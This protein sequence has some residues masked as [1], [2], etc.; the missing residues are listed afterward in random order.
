MKPLLW[1]ALIGLAAATQA[2]L[3]GMRW[4]GGLRL[5][6]LPALVACGALSGWRPTW[7]ILTAV[8][9]GLAHDA[10]SAGPFGLT[11]V[12]YTAPAVL[13]V[14]LQRSLDRDLPWVQAGAGAVV[15]GFAA[16]L[17]SL[18]AGFTGAALVKI[19]LLAMLGAVLTPLATLVREGLGLRAETTT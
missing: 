10:L 17:G 7:T 5:E 4:L 14:T 12:G 9:A 11:V 1:L 6:L 8:V 18:T 15:A 16:L 2:A 19:L 3:P 13:V